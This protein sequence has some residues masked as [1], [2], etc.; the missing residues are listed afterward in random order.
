MASGQGLEGEHDVGVVGVADLSGAGG[1]QRGQQRRPGQ[2]AKPV[3]QLRGGVDEQRADLAPGGLLG[4]D[5]GSA[6]D[7]QRPQRLDAGPLRVGRGLPGQHRSGCAVG[8]QRVGLAPLAPLSGPGPVDLHHGDADLGQ[9][10]ADPGAVAAG[11]LDA[12]RLQRAVTAQPGHRLPVAG[13]G[14]GELLI[15]DRSSG[16]GDH[17]DVDRVLVGVDT[18]DRVCAY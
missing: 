17:R 1:D 4:L 8:V 9:R 6:G 15:V 18:A 2:S 16:A 13:F 3:P 10:S 5:R 11:A 12:D 7:V 14:G